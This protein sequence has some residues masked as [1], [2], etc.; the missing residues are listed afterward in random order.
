M[1]CSIIIC[2]RNRAAMLEQTLRAFQAVT[3]P[4]GWQV[5]MLVA[6]NGSTDGTAEVIKSASHSS[7]EIRHIYEPRPGKSRAQNTALSYA[8]GDVLLFTDDDVEP[9]DS[10]V[11]RMARPL[12]EGRG[13]A[14]AGRIILKE[15]LRRPW[16]THMHEIWLA[17]SIRPTD[18]AP[19]LVGA[20]MGIHRSVF[21]L[22]DNFDE[23]LGPGATGFGEETLLGMQMREAAL[24]IYPV[25]DTFVV[26]NPDASRLMRSQWLKAAKRFGCTR[27]YM[28]Y[29]WEHS[30]VACPALRGKWVQLK[31]FLRRV[32]QPVARVDE[33][34]CPDWEMSYLVMI[35]SLRRYQIESR[36]P[37]NYDRHALHR[38]IL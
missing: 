25:L 38:K 5:E 36:G 21:G 22:I 27:A 2:T 20:S 6:D 13:E 19:G 35:E 11:E 34:G 37:R 7:I 14:V 18:Q 1:D 32:S 24:R 10:W 4:C 17:E 31:L 30:R 3:V 33:E 16:F 29:H 15:H 8:R 26:H 9:A 23:K 28:M 12:M